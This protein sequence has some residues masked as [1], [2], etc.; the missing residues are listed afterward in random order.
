MQGLLGRVAHTSGSFGA[1][2]M[3]VSTLAAHQSGQGCPRARVWGWPGLL[4]SVCAG[5]YNV[6]FSLIQYGEANRSG[7]HGPCK[8]T[9]FLRDPGRKERA[10]R[11]HQE[12]HGPAVIRMGCGLEAGHVG[13]GWV[14]LHMEGSSWAESFTVSRN[15]PALGGPIPPG[16]TGHRCQSM[17]YRAERVVITHSECWE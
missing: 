8:E 4:L 1:K 10:H 17:R 14:G 13:S 5:F 9:L 6:G 2:G 12:V 3:G 15:R 11:P 16:S 7:G